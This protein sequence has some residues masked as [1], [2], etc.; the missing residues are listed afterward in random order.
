MT[1]AGNK[2]AVARA[3]RSAIGS[4]ITR[5]YVPGLIKKEEKVEKKLHMS[6]DN[7]PDFIE[8]WNP[9]MFY[10]FGYGMTIL[11]AGVNYIAGF[12]Q[13][14][15]IL[16]GLVIGYWVRGHSDMEQKTHALLRN[17]LVLGNF[18]FLFEM[19]R[20]EIRQYFIEADDDG[21]P[22][23]RNHRSIVYQRAKNVPETIAFGTRRDTYE[24]GYEFARHSLYPK[25]VDL[26]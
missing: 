9:D 1:V 16:N 6:S 26:S 15:I 4:Q 19:I 11:T 13:E 8:H 3:A 17:Y 25:I 21:K 10:K 7:F 12:C 14:T 22:F 5:S 18:R 23:D 2:S 24:I 20:P